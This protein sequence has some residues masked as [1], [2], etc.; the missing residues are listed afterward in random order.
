M[1]LSKFNVSLCPMG[2]MFNPISIA[3]TLSS[4]AQPDSPSNLRAVARDGVWVSLDAHSDISGNNIE[5]LNKQLQQAKASGHTSLSKADTVIITFGTAWVY[6]HKTTAAVVANCHKVP[7]CEFIRRQLSIEEIVAHFEPL[8]NSIF[9]GKQ[10]I[11]T[12]SPVRHLSDGFAENS[13]SKAIL[14]VAIEEITKRYDNALYFPAFEIVTDDLRDY[15]FY[16]TDLVH[17]S[18][19]AVEYI[20]D[21]F[22]SSILSDKAQQQMAQ[23]AKIVAAAA[24]RPFNPNSEEYARFCEKHFTMAKNLTEIDFSSEC[25]VFEQFSPKN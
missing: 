10:I 24:H 15:R 20:W 1:L 6:E 22:A 16:D 18:E 11:F 13:L 2:I 23:V 19:E 8:F 12:V 4:F 21:K 5:Q 3:R 14:R 7:Q 25:A 17:P 9:K